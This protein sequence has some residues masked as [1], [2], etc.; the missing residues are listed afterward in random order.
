MESET[1][2]VNSSS[3]AASGVLRRTMLFTAYI[4]GLN[5]AP[6]GRDAFFDEKKDMLEYFYAN[7]DYTN[8]KFRKYAVRFARANNLTH[9]T[10]ADFQVIYDSLM[11]MES[12]SLKGGPCRNSPDGMRG[13]MDKCVILLA[14][15]GSVIDRSSV[16]VLPIGH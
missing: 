3:K 16:I 10:D 13:G 8:A 12:F 4:F 2:L 9:S 7:T 15:C 11:D 14:R 1:L 6:F 5:Y